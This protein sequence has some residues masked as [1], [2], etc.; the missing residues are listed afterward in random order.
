MRAKA[1][2]YQGHLEAVG[3]NDVLAELLT[4]NPPMNCTKIL[5]MKGHYFAHT[6]GSHRENKEGLSEMKREERK[7]TLA[8]SIRI[9]YLT[10]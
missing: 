9:P 5:Q 6:E 4:H 1:T 7:L 2:M 8:S 3:I 10:I